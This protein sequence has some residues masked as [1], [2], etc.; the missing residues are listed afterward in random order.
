METFIVSKANILTTVSENTRPDT[1]CPVNE[2][3]S[4]CHCSAK[5]HTCHWCGEKW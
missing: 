5:E 3:V 1:P 2:N 4:H